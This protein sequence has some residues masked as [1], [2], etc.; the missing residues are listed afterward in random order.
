M[1]AEKLKNW[2]LEQDASL[3]GHI[4]VGCIDGN[5][6]CFVGVYDRETPQNPICIGGLSQT[7]HLEKRFKVLVHW[8]NNAVKAA[9]KANAI[10]GLFWG[11][12]HVTMDGI[13]VDVID[14]G[15]GIIS[16]GKD[17][18]GIYEYVIQISLHYKRKE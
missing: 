7:L 15:G 10:Y 12:S 6:E 9:E 16:V 18:N 5:Q 14:P 2:L 13:M 11:K 3:K 17:E 8:T 1:T 4:A